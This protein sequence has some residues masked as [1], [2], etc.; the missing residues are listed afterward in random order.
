EAMMTKGYQALHD[1]IATATE[2]AL[3]KPLPRMEVTFENLS[4]TA[5]IVVKDET[6]LETE[7]PT[8]FTVAKS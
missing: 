7:L 4:V 1:H 8:I 5:D 6:Q 2:R 3:G